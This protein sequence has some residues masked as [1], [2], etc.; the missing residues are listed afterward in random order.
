MADET[1]PTNF[2][3]GALPLSENVPGY[4]GTVV[5][6]PDPVSTEA[7]PGANFVDEQSEPN[8]PDAMPAP[9][10]AVWSAPVPV[11]VP[12][13]APEPE[14]EAEAPLA[15]PVLTPER[16]VD[17]KQLNQGRPV[18][19]Y[20]QF[21]I[22]VVY[23]GLIGSQYKELTDKF[24]E[25]KDMSTPERQD[26]QTAAAAVLWPR[27]PEGWFETAL[28]GHAQTLALLVRQQS[29]F[30]LTT[31]EGRVIGKMLKTEEL[32]PQEHVPPIEPTDEEIQ[33]IRAQ[34]PGQQIFLATFPDGKQNLFTPLPRIEW[35]SINKRLEANPEIDAALEVARFCVK[36]PST[37]NWD[38]E[39]AGKVNALF[40]SIMTQ[41]AFNLEPQV[42][43]L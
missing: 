42:V 24:R 7:V 5:P 21:G 12:T 17:C 27:L 14:A 26:E 29:G 36:W 23:K 43:E 13:P 39:L 32:D 2:A 33:T 41:S 37:P 22:V 3:T 19:R 25:E 15:W 10:S 1:E 11:P 4:P 20:E 40:D 35:T 8:A 30:S 38:N 28:A 9:Q 31:T 34:S 6:D 16:I 18:Y